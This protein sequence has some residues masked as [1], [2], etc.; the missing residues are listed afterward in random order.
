MGIIGIFKRQF[1]YFF[2]T[3]ENIDMCDNVRSFLMC[4][5]VSMLNTSKQVGFVVAGVSHLS[6]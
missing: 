5:L 2:S 1:F 6:V 3:L 4:T